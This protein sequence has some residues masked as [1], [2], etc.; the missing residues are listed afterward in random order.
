MTT[1]I[2]CQER[3]RLLDHLRPA[4]LHVATAV[5]L[6]RH[7]RLSANPVLAAVLEERAAGHRDAADRVRCALE[8]PPRARVG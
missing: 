4:A 7:A 5:L 3:R 2:G 1:R 6:E 8:F